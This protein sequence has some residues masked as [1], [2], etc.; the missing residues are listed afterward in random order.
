MRPVSR[1]FRVTYTY[2]RRSLR[3]ML[4]SA[5]VQMRPPWLTR[6]PLRRSSALICM[7][8]WRRRRR[9]RTARETERRCGVRGKEYSDARAERETDELL[10]RSDRRQHAQGGAEGKGR[11]DLR[12]LGR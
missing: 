8:T 11:V 10:T 1:S 9:G 6:W 3:M 2:W 7:A 12:E 4:Q 5:T